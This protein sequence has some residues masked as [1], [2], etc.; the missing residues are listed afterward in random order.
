[1]VIVVVKLFRCVVL[2]DW[3]TVRIVGHFRLASCMHGWSAMSV[4]WP[5]MSVSWSDWL[6]IYTIGQLYCLGI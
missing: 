2:P 4:G 5:S 6:E 1:M 3:T